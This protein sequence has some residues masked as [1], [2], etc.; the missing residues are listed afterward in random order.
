MDIEGLGIAVVEN[1]VQAGL[2]KTPGDLYFLDPKEVASLDRMGHKSAEN[3]IAAVDKSKANDLWRLL[4]AFG[5]RQVG[6]KAAKTIA[7]HFGSMDAIWH[8]S[9]EELMQINDVGL[10][11]AT[12][13]R[14]WFGSEQS[15]HLIHRLKEAGVNMTAITTGNDRRF[16]GM[17]FVLTG[18]M[19]R[20]TREEASLIIEEH[21]GKASSSVS[22][23]TTYVIAGEN[24]GSKLKKAQELGIT[25]LTDNNHYKY[26]KV[27][28]KCQYEFYNSI[29]I[30]D[31]E[32]VK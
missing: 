12:N 15:Q 27:F 3:L 30:F 25:V 6:Q 16:E 13:L 31:S 29:V 26:T 23:K 11:T 2:V 5:I 20:F 22:K 7:A 32:G 8:A 19:E 21:G 28:L 14:S 4:Y 1:L 18:A 24:A 17:T 10:I 9:E